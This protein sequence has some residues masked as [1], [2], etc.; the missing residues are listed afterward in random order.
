M[1]TTIVI[2]ATLQVFMGGGCPFVPTDNCP[3]ADT[4]SENEPATVQ[5]PEVPNCQGCLPYEPGRVTCDGWC[6]DVLFI[7]LFHPGAETCYRGYGEQDGAQCCY[8]AEGCPIGD[9]VL[10][11]AGTPDYVGPVTA[12]LPDGSCDWLSDPWRLL[13]HWY[14]DVF[15]WSQGIVLG[16]CP[17]EDGD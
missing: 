17:A 10:L 15:L 9:D 13:T 2:L 6:R 12:E 7:D 16:T 8:D 1:K 3:C 14:Y 11:A 4:G 5:C